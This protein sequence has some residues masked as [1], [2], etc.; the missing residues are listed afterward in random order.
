[1]IIY[2]DESGDLGFD[3]E[4]K[5]PSK[6]FVIAVLVCEG[7]TSSGFKCDTGQ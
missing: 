2:L 5:K 7:H 4:H 3:F 6:K 1:L